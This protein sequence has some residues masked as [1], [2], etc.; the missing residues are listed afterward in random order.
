[1]QEWKPDRVKSLNLLAGQVHLSLFQVMRF[2]AANSASAGL[3]R[4]RSSKALH[5]RL[6]TLPRMIALGDLKGFEHLFRHKITK[7][8]NLKRKP[9]VQNQGLLNVMDLRESVSNTCS[10]GA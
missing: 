1:M 6:S 4:T 2:P 5:S 9:Q 7:N 10:C 3:R 8:T